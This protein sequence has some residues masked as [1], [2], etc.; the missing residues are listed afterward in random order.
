M[1]TEACGGK[2][3]LLL[4]CLCAH[5]YSG[6]KGYKIEEDYQHHGSIEQKDVVQI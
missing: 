3:D 6:V 5:K 4:L 1:V 2:S